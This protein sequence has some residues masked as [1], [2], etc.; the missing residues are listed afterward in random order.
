MKNEGLYVI[1]MCIGVFINLRH[2]SFVVTMWT[3][4]CFSWMGTQVQMKS[5]FRLNGSLHCFHIE[6]HRKAGYIYFDAVQ[7][8]FFIEYYCN[9]ITAIMKRLSVCLSN[10]IWKYKHLIITPFH[11]DVKK[12]SAYFICLNYTAI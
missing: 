5:C 1:N 8:S 12:G 11:S 10:A 7:V 2:C 9:Y 3:C 6:L 4:F